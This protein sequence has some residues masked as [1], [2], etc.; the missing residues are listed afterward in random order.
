MRSGAPS[1][2]FLFLFPLAGEFLRSLLSS[3][4]GP[5]YRFLC[6]T[7]TSPPSHRKVADRYNLVV[8]DLFTGHQI[9]TLFHFPPFI[10]HIFSPDPPA[11][12]TFMELGQSFTIEPSLESM[13]V[14]E[15]GEIGGGMM[16]GDGWT[17]VTAVS[18]PSCRFCEG[19]SPAWNGS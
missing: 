4:F 6:L 5:S 9:G 16:W 11:S 7:T 19:K 18:C 13:F 15:G 17:V 3:S 10:D 14:G 2:S 12:T 8:C 1:S